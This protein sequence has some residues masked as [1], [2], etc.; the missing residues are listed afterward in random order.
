[1]LTTINLEA[2]QESRAFWGLQVWWQLGGRGM[3]RL[4]FPVLPR[5][6]RPTLKTKWNS[7][8]V[9]GAMCVHIHLCESF[10]VVTLEIAVGQAHS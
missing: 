3:D 5:V 8:S 2:E 9:L 10:L 6:T 4:N 1:M 7:L